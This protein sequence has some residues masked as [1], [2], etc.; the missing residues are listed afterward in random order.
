MSKVATLSTIIDTDVKKALTD[1]CKRKG[2]KIRYVIE[3]ALIEQLEDE[4]DIEA[5]RSR[6][7]E[8][9]VSFNPLKAK[10]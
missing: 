9:R 6:K 8:E 10:K 3:N 1:F 7:N 4:I 2:L 5:Y